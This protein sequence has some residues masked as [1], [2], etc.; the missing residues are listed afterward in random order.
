MASTVRGNLAD[1]F[2][3]PIIGATVLINKSGTGVAAS[4]FSD[5]A[6]TIAA[7]NPLTTGQDG[8]YGPVFAPNGRYDLVITAGGYTFTAGDSLAEFVFD[9][10]SAKTATGTYT[11]D[12]RDV[13]IYADASGGNVTINLPALSSIL[14]VNRQLTIMKTDATANTVTIVP[15]GADTIGGAVNY[16]IFNKN[17]TTYLLGKSGTDWKLLASAAAFTL[18][19]GSTF[20]SIALT[21]TVNSIPLSGSGGTLPAGWAG[22]LNVQYLSSGTSYTPTLGT[23]NI[24]V[25]LIGGGG[26][27]GG[28]GATGVGV[29][30]TAT[31]GGS[32]TYARKYFTGV[33][34]GPYTYAIGALGAGAAAGANN[35]GNGGNTTFTGPGAIT[36]TAPGGVGGAAMN[37]A[38]PP[39]INSNNNGGAP[40][41]NAD[42]SDVGVTGGFGV[43][44]AATILQSGAGASSYWGGGA[45]PVVN[46][47][48]GGNASPSFGAGGSGGAAIASQAAQAGG[49]GKAGL[50]I[51]WEFS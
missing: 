31:G 3:K 42:F 32:G 46:S 15:N 14:L 39:F 9:P 49:N 13:I 4:I 40:P 51:V 50:I 45:F 43:S 1:N 22:L 17:A 19:D 35:G 30:A 28:T 11:V 24:L 37:G 8:A 29:V 38:T 27:G 21:P 20:R 48:G 33:G 47:T 18:W 36:V 7:T 16:V 26:G 10:T 2:G 23:H 34:A 44:L 5:N 6:M 41:T 12:D 25:E